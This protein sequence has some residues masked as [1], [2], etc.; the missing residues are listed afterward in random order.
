MG[1]LQKCPFLCGCELL[2][3]TIYEIAIWEMWVS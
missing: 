1:K 3:N 2:C